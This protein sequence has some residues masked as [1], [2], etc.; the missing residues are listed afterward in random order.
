M[1]T[2][3]PTGYKPDMGLWSTTNMKL[4]QMFPLARLRPHLPRHAPAVFLLCACATLAHAQAPEPVSPAKKE[5]VSKLVRLQQPGIENLARSLV[6]E[7]AAI[8][9]ERASQVVA[10]RVPADKQDALGKDVQGDVQKYL[11]DTVPQVRSRAVA[12][13]PSTIG[14][15][16]EQKFTEDELRQVIAVLESPAFAKYQQLSSEMQQALQSKLVAET[17][18]TVGPRVQALEKS[19]GDR[20]AAAQGPASGNAPAAKPPAKAPGK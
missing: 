14:S 5:L 1:H 15:L 2:R 16:L 18:S 17:R 4:Q 10:A 13:A 3:T 6:E 11:N 8:L 19:I 9:L 12:L 7:P 20:L